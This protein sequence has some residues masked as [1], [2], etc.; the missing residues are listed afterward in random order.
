MFA[1]ILAA[2]ITA[3]V[4]PLAPIETDVPENIAPSVA[5]AEQAPPSAAAFELGRSRSVY[6]IRPAVDVPLTLAGAVIAAIRFFGTETIVHRSCPCDPATLNPVDRGTVRYHDRTLLPVSHVALGIMIATPIVLD[7]IDLGFTKPF[8]EDLMILVETLSIDTA[9]QAATAMIV[10]RPRPLA[11]AGD[12][13]LVEK[14]EGYVSFYAGHVATAVATM[15][16]VAQTL[17]LRYGHRVW[18]WLLPVAMG[19]AMGVL[20]IRS[21]DHFPTDTLVGALAG[22]AVGI[23]VPWLH[24]RAPETQV[25]LVPSPGG[26]GLA[27]RF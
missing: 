19:T 21:G 5:P 22:F 24:E 11:Y 7:A 13:E 3:Q 14:G 16:V 8:F 1:T 26:A 2:L 25:R 20:R 10:Q 23:T 6:Q 17:R 15:S 18:P 27:G 9:F 4:E 12:P